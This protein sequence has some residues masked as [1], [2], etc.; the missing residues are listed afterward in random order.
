MSADL[1]R[2]ITF[3]FADRAWQQKLL[4]PLLASFVPGLNLILW[5]GYALTIARNMLRNERHPVPMWD[6]W[7][8]ISV[9]GFLSIMA[10]VFYFAP[11]LLVVCCLGVLSLLV[12][13]GGDGTFLALRC[14]FYVASLIYFLAGNLLLTV[15]HLRYAE[16]DQFAVYLDIGGRLRDLRAK[17]NTFVS[18][19]ITQTILS[20]LI[21]SLL[22]IMSVTLVVGTSVAAS[23]GGIGIVCA[24]P[25]LLV[26]LFGVLG[27]VMVS[28][29]ANGH[30]LGSTLIA[31]ASGAAMR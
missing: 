8:D 1:G 29:L 15:G 19:F 25:V 16:T 21:V 9:R 26:V 2:A 6:E 3:A 22:F 13:G 17:P 7:S 23:A 5:S 10:A 30:I 31:L 28:F 27:M 20:F 18:L 11:V 24:I 12:G 14:A 4:V